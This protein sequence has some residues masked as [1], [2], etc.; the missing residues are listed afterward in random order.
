MNH[1][2]TRNRTLEQAQEAENI[3]AAAW[4]EVCSIKGAVKV[5]VTAAVLG[6]A[7][8]IGSFGLFILNEIINTGR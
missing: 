8:Y 4:A 7:I 2:Y 6:A 1:R 5:I 3:A